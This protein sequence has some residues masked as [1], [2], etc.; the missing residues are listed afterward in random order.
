M[1]AYPVVLGLGFSRAIFAGGVSGAITISRDDELGFPA[2]MVGPAIRTF[3]IAA[4]ER[5]VGLSIGR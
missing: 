1:W 4:I 2:I 5:R 3:P